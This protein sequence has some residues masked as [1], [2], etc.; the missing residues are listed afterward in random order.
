MVL[1]GY[2]QLLCEMFIC[3]KREKLVLDLTTYV[4]STLALKQYSN[5]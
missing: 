5:F 1:M 3:I 4:H 2:K